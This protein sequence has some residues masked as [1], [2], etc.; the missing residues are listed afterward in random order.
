MAQTKQTV[1]IV[2][3]HTHWDREWRYPIWK[4]RMLLLDVFDHL[5]EL[6]ENDPAYSNFLM[7]GQCVPV[8]DYLEVRPENEQ[9]VRDAVA[10]GKLS[11]GPWYTLPDLYPLDGECLVRNLLWGVR[12]S[13]SYGRSMRIGYNS[14]GWGQTAQFPQIY[15]GFGFDFILA[16]KNLSKLRAP[17]SE[18]WWEAPD[19]TR[20]LTTR[21]GRI[22]RA[23]TFFCVMI[24]VRYN[25]EVNA[26][27]YEYTPDQPWLTIHNADADRCHEDHF[28]IDREHAYHDDWIE[29]GFQDAFQDTQDTL[30][31]DVRLLL[32]GCD[33]SDEISDLSKVIADANRILE[34]T[35]IEHGSLDD[36]A[37]RVRDELDLDSLGTVEGEM[38]DGPAAACSAN[39]LA[40]RIYLKIAN[41]QAQNALMRRAEP[42]RSALAIAGV[43]YPL[44]M[45]RIAWKH[46]LLS[47]PHDSINGVTQDKTADDVLNRLEQ[48][49]EIGHVLV[50][51]GIGQL[52]WR[53][54]YSSF[55]A[56]DTCLLVFNPLPRPTH[57][58][59]RLGVD[60]LQQPLDSTY[61]FELED[62]QGQR[63]RVQP[64]SI[65]EEK[66]PLHD[67]FSR[68]WPHNHDKHMVWAD[69]GELPACGYKVFK[70]VTTQTFRRDV[71]WW[72][73]MRQSEGDEL[74]QHPDV[75]EN[76]HLHV[77]VNPDA[78]LDVTDKSTGRRYESLH[79]FEDA[80][81]V[82]DY[83]AYY[84][85]YNDQVHTS[86]GCPARI[87]REDNG[88][89]AAS[90]ATEITMHLPE[91]AD[92]AHSKYQGP[93]RRAEA[94]R[95]FVIR[96]TF[97][98]KR[99][100]RRLDVRT[101]ID[102]N[103]EDHRLRVM[104]PTGLAATHSDASGHFTVD[105][106]PIDPPRNEDGRFWP[107]M[108]TKPQQHFCSVSDGKVGFALLNNCLTEFEAIDS[109]SCTLALTL[110]RAVRNRVCTEWRATGAFPHQKGGQCLRQMTFEY[111][112]CPHAGDWAHAQLYEQADQLNCPP[113]VYQTSPRGRGD[114]PTSH[115]YLNIEPANLV[116]SAFKKAE[117]R[118]SFILR[119]FNPTA[120]T[121][122]GRIGLPNGIGKAWQTNLDEQREQ[123]LALD[124]NTLNLEVPAHR[125]V[126]IE[127]AGA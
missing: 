60:L 51:D 117:D 101:V 124:Q 118:D 59:C 14:F 25:R 5:L 121:L 13:E 109:E 87:W 106:R 107:E 52:A 85:P 77:R 28:R 41:K 33:F 30:A 119:L 62:D 1:G 17:H 79:W 86:R 90:I 10:D 71:D 11:I 96:S 3:P 9:R 44:H 27:Q 103:V 6:F 37:R 22:K 116:L 73:E 120:E 36:Y 100:A 54:D 23:N 56:D 108:Q 50:E 15:A 42:F 78:T 91:R 97:T 43:E 38:R 66:T 105:R 127:L 110:F 49:I 18:F 83:W 104:F 26:A 72:P 12:I 40:T 94:T 24:P 35:S 67:P 2:V 4:T 123:E 53:L 32:N 31:P 69:L 68:P 82:G 93:D 99:G 46:M 98:L 57:A 95:P 70:V 114:W 80:G 34:D 75:M 92:R 84:P 45:L 76:E 81:D 64:I 29:R 48:A 115:S 39:A 65:R 122:A 16:A 19:G 113:A 89:L 112:I 21:M 20:V 55:E 102:N 7:D 47:H 126:T 63:H 61:W 58:V 111:A 125:I 88:P 8:E 74:S